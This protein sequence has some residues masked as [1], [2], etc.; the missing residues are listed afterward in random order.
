MEV[1][2]R[3]DVNRSVHVSYRF[4]NLKCVKNAIA[5]V[6]KLLKDRVGSSMYHLATVPVKVCCNNLNQMESSISELEEH[7]K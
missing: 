6:L 2:C 5:R 1:D 4:G 3:N 7:H